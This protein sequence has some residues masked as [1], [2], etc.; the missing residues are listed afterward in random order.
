MTLYESLNVVREY[1]F[2]LYVKV[3]GDS[4]QIN[5]TSNIITE[6]GIEINYCDIYMNN[7]NLT[8]MTCE[9]EN[10]NLIIT[11]KI[12]DIN[13]E[14]YSEHSATSF[15]VNH[16]NMDITMTVDLNNT[17]TE[18]KVKFDSIEV[19]NIQ[20]P[21][22]NYNNIDTDYPLIN[23]IANTNNLKQFCIDHRL[24]VL[25]N[26]DDD[27]DSIS[28]YSLSNSELLS[29]IVKHWDLERHGFNHI[30]KDC[31]DITPKDIF[32]YCEDFIK[33]I[34]SINVIKQIFNSE[35][36]NN[37]FYLWM[38]QDFEYEEEREDINNEIAVQDGF[39]R[40][41]SN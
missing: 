13:I 31:P 23:L 19:S 27:D 7:N 28:I 29:Y 11:G 20:I 4:F 34:I 14:L 37:F 17:T 16:I 15:S 41:V 25:G 5:D 39:D 26:D 18:E 33:D 2:D 24:I 35:E 32:P 38:I 9:L 21:P 8:D 10:D 36:A 30:F 12:V 6:Q 22:I 1:S 40:Y 3:N